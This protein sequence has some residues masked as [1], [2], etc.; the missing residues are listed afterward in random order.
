MR[1]GPIIR[2]RI[3]II[4][5]SLFKGA[6]TARELMDDLELS[7]TQIFQTLTGMRARGEVH[8]GDYRK[9]TIEMYGCPCTRWNPV[10]VLGA[11]KDKEMP[12]ES[13]SAQSR[14]KVAKRKA[15]QAEKVLKVAREKSEIIYSLPMEFFRR[16]A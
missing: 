7:K 8:I 12:T 4:K 16:A 15:K 10:Y 3:P 2:S 14:N 9:A 6:K 13:K 11:G 1:D 5:A